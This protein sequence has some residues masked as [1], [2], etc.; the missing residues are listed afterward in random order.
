MKKKAIKS[1]ITGWIIISLIAGTVISCTEDR[2][3]G[4]L[5]NSVIWRITGADLP[6]PSYLFGTVHLMDSN[7]L[8]IHTTVIEQLVRS[9]AVV[10]ETDIADPGYRGQ[11]IA[12][13]MMEKD[14]LDGILSAR[15]YGALKEFFRDEFNFPLDAVKRMKP[16]YL[17][18]LI[19]ALK[20]DDNDGSLEE[21][22]IR[23]AREEEKRITGISTLEKESEILSGIP[24]PDQVE[25]LF[26][27]IEAFRNG[28]SDAL[29]RRILQAYRQAD[30]EKIGKLVSGSLMNHPSIFKQLF[31]VRNASWIP[32]MTVLMRRQSCFFAVGVGHL[33]GETGLIRLLRNE[34]YKVTPVRMDFWFHD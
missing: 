15:Q 23:I 17:A 7:D 9:E 1:S 13:A 33:P 18:S 20:A 16:F 12:F 21:E 10:F 3:D 19:G 28:R 25:Y 14:S 22:L 32:T 31:A 6:G 26:E 27:E 11:V 5:R 4:S 2:I 24:L 29:K 30:I 34:G 8:F